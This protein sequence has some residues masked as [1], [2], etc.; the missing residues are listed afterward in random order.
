MRKLARDLRNVNRALRNKNREVLEVERI[1][2]DKLKYT[3]G[4]SS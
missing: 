1:Q 2:R 4:G 3:N